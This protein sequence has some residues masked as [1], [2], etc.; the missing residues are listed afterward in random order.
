METKAEKS[1]LLPSVSWETR[2]A[3]A[4]IQPE[5]EDMRTRNADARGRRRWMSQLKQ[6]EQILLLSALLFYLGHQQM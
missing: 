4:V 6:G 5:S 1:H 2:E 3:G